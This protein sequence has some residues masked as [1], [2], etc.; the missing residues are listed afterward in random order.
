MPR[1]HVLTYI[2]LYTRRI[3]QTP[4]GKVYLSWILALLFKT[5][6]IFVLTIYLILV[7][8]SNVLVTSIYLKKVNSEKHFMHNEIG[9]YYILCLEDMNFPTIFLLCRQTRVIQNRN[10][11]LMQ[12]VLNRSSVLKMLTS[13]LLCYFRG[14]LSRI[15]PARS[16][17]QEFFITFEVGGNNLLTVKT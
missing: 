6:S 10:C 13:Q 4:S 9:I 8:L 1:E 14:D 16:P 11:Q 2:L 15:T 12:K 7:W 17:Q 5:L 3:L